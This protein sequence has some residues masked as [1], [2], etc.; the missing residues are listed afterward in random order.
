MESPTASISSILVVEDDAALRALFTALMARNGYHVE[1]VTNGKQALE[2]VATRDY[3][4]VVLDLMMPVYSGYDLLREL[5]ESRPELLRRVIVT[6]GVAERE[7]AK[8]KGSKVFAILRKPFDIHHLLSTVAQCARQGRPRQKRRTRQPKLDDGKLDDSIHRL[9]TTL[10]ELKMML[11]CPPASDRERVLR[12]EVRRA[13]LSLA[14]LLDAAAA[15]AAADERAA[16]MKRLARSAASVAVA[17][18]MPA[19]EH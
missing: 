12:G 1:C 6:T 18:V 15:A 8:I 17:P 13:V 5:E 4:A 11:A 10:P 3:D 9:D 7:L 16:E 2:A 19:P 14:A